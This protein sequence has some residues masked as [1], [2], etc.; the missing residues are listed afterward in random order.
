MAWAFVAVQGALLVALALLPA[1]DVW[2]LPGWAADVARM[3]QLLGVALLVVGL[4]GLGT[5]LTPLPTPAPGSTLRTGGPFRLV[6]HPIYTG[7]D[8]LALGLAL[9]SGNP[10]SL[11]CALAL[12]G[13]FMAKARWEEARLRRRYPDYGA[14]AARVGRFMPL[15]GRDRIRSG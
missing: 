4:L 12:V 10:W 1:D 3:V 11:V 13:W 2:V 14:Y 8:L 9:R 15:V 7:I 5:S 6:R